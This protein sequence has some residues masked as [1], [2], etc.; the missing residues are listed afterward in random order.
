MTISGDYGF[1]ITSSDLHRINYDSLETESIPTLE[2]P[3]KIISNGN[4]LVTVRGTTNTY[5]Y[6]HNF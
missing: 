5:L 6:N 3:L 1:Y 2:T 4:G